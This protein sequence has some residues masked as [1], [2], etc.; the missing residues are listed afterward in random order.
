M[1][2]M[3]DMNTIFETEHQGAMIRDI[4]SLAPQDT[5]WKEWFPICIV[6]QR[7]Q[8]SLTKVGASLFFDQGF[9]CFDRCEDIVSY[10]ETKGNNLYVFALLSSLLSIPCYISKILM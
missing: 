2:A 10:L 9:L 6:V 5:L 4:K 1:E 3:L 8:S 7:T